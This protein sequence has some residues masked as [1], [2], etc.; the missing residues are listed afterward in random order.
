MENTKIRNMIISGESW[1]IVEDDRLEK[2][3]WKEGGSEEKPDGVICTYPN[4]DIS[5]VDDLYDWITDRGFDPDMISNDEWDEL[6]KELDPEDR[7]YLLEDLNLPSLKG[8]EVLGA[9]DMAY[10]DHDS[11]I[12]WNG[13]FYIHEFETKETTLANFT[14][15]EIELLK[16]STL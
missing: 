6:I 3:W 5:Y 15:E 14:P 11:L 16:H 4:Q 7:E 10:G 1:Q 8:E 2:T 12:D 13:N 9:I